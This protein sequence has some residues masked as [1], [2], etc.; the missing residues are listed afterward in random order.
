[1]HSFLQYS[2]SLRYISGSACW[3]AFNTSRAKRWPTVVL[4]VFFTKF[5]QSNSI[6]NRSCTSSFYFLITHQPNYRRNNNF[7]FK[8]CFEMCLI[9]K[10]Y[11][12]RL[13]EPYHGLYAA[14]QALAP[15][16]CHPFFTLN[17]A[18]HGV[19][20]GSLVT[21]MPNLPPAT[22]KASRSRRLFVYNLLHSFYCFEYNFTVVVALYFHGNFMVDDKLQDRKW[23]SAYNWV[24]CIYNSCSSS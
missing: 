15:S 23:L 17:K 21:I 20:F 22:Y 8:Y 6:S 2:I 1:M 24:L 16:R 5:T 18:I 12:G 4:F 11:I 14:F 7:S 13:Y 10:S 19:F 3:G 9:R